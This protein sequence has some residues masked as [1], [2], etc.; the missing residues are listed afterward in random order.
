[1]QAEPSIRFVE[2]QG[3]HDEDVARRIEGP[4]GGLDERHR[5]IHGAQ[6]LPEAGGGDARC[7]RGGTCSRDKRPTAALFATMGDCGPG[8]R[9][10]QDGETA[11]RDWPDR[12]LGSGH[13]D[14]GRNGA[15]WRWKR[16]RRQRETWCSGASAVRSDAARLGIASG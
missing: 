15:Q 8:F 7:A 6:F 11:G 3:V 12:L 13:D 1:M 16:A 9:R 2:Y 14:R 4:H 10:R 5:K